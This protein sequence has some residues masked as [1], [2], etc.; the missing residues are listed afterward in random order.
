MKCLSEERGEKEK[1]KMEGRV[2]GKVFMYY[3]TFQS[4]LLIQRKQTYF[5]FIFLKSSIVSVIL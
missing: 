5:V 2:G 4:Y 1:G 3:L